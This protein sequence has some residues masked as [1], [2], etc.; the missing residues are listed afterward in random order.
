MP[1]RPIRRTAAAVAAVAALLVA[2]HAHAQP[3]ADAPSAGTSSTDAALVGAAPADATLVGATP[4]DAAPVGAAPADAASAN[5]SSASAAQAGVAAAAAG[6]LARRLV[7]GDHLE[8]EYGGTRF[9]DHG[10]TLD[11]LFALAAAGV[12]EDRADAI[13][14]WFARPETVATYLHFGDPNTSYAGSYAK[15]AL[16]VQVRGLDPT[17][18]GGVDLIAGL[19]ALQ[20]PSGRFSDVPQDFS[21]GFTQ[22]FAVLAL[23]RRQSA[24][25]NAVD[26]MLGTRCPG[27]G[28]PVQLLAEPCVPDVDTTAMAV[29]ALLAVDRTPADDA[30]LA[31]ALT[32][33]AGQQQPGGGFRE[34]GKDDEGN[35]NST[36]LA[37]QALRA[38]GRTAEADRAAAFLAGLAQGCSAAGADRGAIAYD[39]TGFT[40]ATAQAASAQAVL[41]LVGVGY[42]ELSAEGAVTGVPVLDC[43]VAPTSTTPAASTSDTTTTTTAVAAAGGGRELARTG[44]PVGPATWLGSLL[45]AAGALLLVVARQRHAG[46]GK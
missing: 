32:W 18:F 37:A 17:D 44:V 28:F 35:A 12:A 14:A 46:V 45:L 31:E 1:I 34:D 25:R 22:A 29:Q 10:L 38:G 9:V 6:W 15:L 2:P 42:A 30:A 27:T 23:E 26:F 5:A 21:N 41:G 11:A 3:P 36:G 39:R 8:T 4:A 19:T 13:T 20:A 33:L 43:P 24:P 7:D 40:A 16:A